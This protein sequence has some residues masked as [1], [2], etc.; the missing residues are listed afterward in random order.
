M[1]IYLRFV[2]LIH[3]LEAEFVRTHSIDQRGVKLL[4]TIS[5]HHSQER[6]LK[7]TDL[8][9]LAQFGS[10]ATIHRSLRL[11]RDSGL[12]LDFYKGRD[13]RTKY[14]CSSEIANYYYS[15]LGAVLMESVREAS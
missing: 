13:R 5:I 4:E 7:I 15:Q 14:L 8:M 11:L 9:T 1:K 6:S 2:N 12:V 10:P 3:A